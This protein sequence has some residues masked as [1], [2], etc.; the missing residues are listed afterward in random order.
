MRECLRDSIVVLLL[1][2]SATAQGSPGNPGTPS[3][4]SVTIDLVDDHGDVS[5]TYEVGETFTVQVAG[6]TP[7][8]GY[9]LLLRNEHDQ[10]LGWAR[11]A[12]DGAGTIEPTVLMW[13]GGITGPDPAGRHDPGTG[14]KTLAE[15]EQYLA[16]HTLQVEVRESD[17]GHPGQGKLVGKAP[18]ATLAARTSPMFWFSESDGTYRNA[19]DSGKEMLYVTGTHL[20]AGAIVDL[21]VCGEQPGWEVGAAV[22]DTTGYGGAPHKK[23]ITLAPN[24]TSFSLA[25]WPAVYQRAGSFD[26]V[27]RI[28]NPTSGSGVVLKSGDFVTHDHEAGVHIVPPPPL[29]VGG[30]DIEATLVGKKTNKS[31]FPGIRWQHLFVRHDK[32]FF[33]LDPSDVPSNHVSPKRAAV[34]VTPAR[35]AAEWQ[36]LPL[37]SDETEVVEV[38]AVKQ[39]T[40]ETSV[41]GIWQDADPIAGHSA[42]DVVVDFITDDW[43]TSP[44]TGTAT[45]PPGGAGNALINGVYDPGYDI[46]DSLDGDGLR[47]LE[48]PSEFG[49]YPIGRTEYDFPDAYDIPWGDYQ[50]Q[51]VD[52]RAVVAYPGQS[53]GTDVPMWGTNERFPLIVI[54]HGNHNVCLNF[55]CTCSPN[56]RIP[57]HK[58]YDYL[59][60]LWASHGFIAVSVDGY[61]I[62][63]CP[64]DR[65]IE[66]GALILEHIRYWEDWDDPNI[67]DPTFNGRFYD[68]VNTHDVGIAGHSRGGEGVAAAV[69]INQDL[70]LGHDIKSALTIAPTDYNW[71]TPPGGGPVE[72]VIADVPLFNIMGSSD[73]DVVDLDGAQ[74][75]DRSEPAGRRKNKTQAYVYG[76]DHNSWN[77]VWIDPLWNGGSDGVGSNRITA[78]QQQDTGR[79]YMTAWWL[80][81]LQGKT[82]Y[83]AYHRG[84]VASSRLSGV[85]TYWSYDD[86]DHLTVDDFQQMPRDNSVNT[87]GGTNTA[88]PNPQTW[89]E[90]GMRPGD[91]DNSFRQDTDGL[92]VGWNATTTYESVIPTANED[93][94][95]YVALS[96]RATQICDNN[97]L[98]VGGSQHFLVNLEDTSGR[99][100]SV[101]VDTQGFA[102]IPVSYRRPTGKRKSMLSTVRVPLK[103]F[104]ANSSGID[105]THVAKVIITFDATGLLGIDNLQFTK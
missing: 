105:L 24:S 46:L 11:A 60:D 93:V 43:F 77:T 21:W 78:Q 70:A 28:N 52:M 61:D 1:A 31:S 104:T 99:R 6:V 38:R 36:R 45:S 35:D 14:W 91:Y 88:N 101:S 25:V 68:R 50:D 8:H 64:T 39:G 30:S 40:L 94:S 12:A 22:V 3:G 66:R 65:F 47:V 102:P 63:G 27:A 15:A 90:N 59:L 18:V 41:F 2:A 32:V 74:T 19:F 72:F 10:V 4:A 26:L 7:K 34:W 58:G 42:M 75:H 9:D 49:A 29:I 37:L 79:V 86:Q 97:V 82:D 44:F 96:V 33:A 103:V 80:A 89:Q 62:T 76:A 57:N 81:T 55:G 73:G 100:Q 84:V 71:S 20:P 98:N 56:N 17:F 69:Q 53:A 5:P 54:L 51:N 92:I 87:L 85:S 95:Q 83:L 23:R 67:T 13:D 16:A 48:D